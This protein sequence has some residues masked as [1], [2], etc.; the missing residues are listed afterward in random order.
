MTLSLLPSPSGSGLPT[1]TIILVHAHTRTGWPHHSNH[2]A[3]QGNNLPAA[4]REAR[5]R[6]M[7]KEGG[8]VKERDDKK[9]GDFFS[10][11]WRE[12]Q[13]V[14]GESAKHVS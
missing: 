7:K 5:D 14:E 9:E 11:N 13:G 2:R 4:S 10:K 6:E 12:S 3:T 1:H 8:V